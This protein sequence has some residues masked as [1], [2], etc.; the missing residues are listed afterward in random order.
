MPSMDLQVVNRALKDIHDSFS[1]LLLE[2]NYLTIDDVV[3]WPN[4]ISGVQGSLAY[5]AEYQR[6]VDRSQ[7]SFLLRDKSFFQFYFE[8]ENSSVTSAKLAYYP[9]PVKISGAMDDI[10]EVAE[11]SGVDLLEEFYLG[12]ENWIDRGIDIVNTSHI[13]LDFDSKVTSHSPCHIQFGG[14]NQFRIPSKGLINPFI[15][16][17]WVCENMGI[18]DFEDVVQR[19][20][21]L[22]SVRYHIKRSYDTGGVKDNYPHIVSNA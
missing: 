3:S 1:S 12:A 15:F 4:Y 9:S 13:R 6:F 19:A 18:D 7:Y 21:Y 2:T 22:R 5:A 8:F 20:P 10:I 11:M 14:L 16:F 17:E